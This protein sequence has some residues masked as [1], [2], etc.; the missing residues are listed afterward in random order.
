MGE[1]M[2]TETETSRASC[3]ASQTD[4][5][6]PSESGES[7]RIETPPKRKRG[8]ARVL[9]AGSGRRGLGSIFRSS[10][11]DRKS[12]KRVFAATW[13][14]SYSVGGCQA[15][16]YGFKTRE[17]A[18]AMLEKR[19]N[20]VRD[21]TALPPEL[22]KIVLRDLTDLF[23]LD[24]QQSGRRSAE[25]IRHALK[26]LHAY[27]DD[28]KYPVADLTGNRVKEYVSDRLRSMTRYNRRPAPATINR[29]LAA[30]KRAFHLAA[31]CDPPLVQKI[32]PITM[33]GEAPARSGFFEIA[34]FNR[35][36]AKLPEY[37]HAPLQVARM[38][39]WRVASEV[40]SRKVK[41]LDLAS[42]WLRLDP[43]ETKNGDGREFPLTPALR[44]V[45]VAQRERTRALEKARGEIIPWLFHDD[46]GKP[47]TSFRTAWLNACKR[48]GIRKL[49]Q[50]APCVPR[51]R[52]PST[53]LSTTNQQSVD[54]WGS[55]PG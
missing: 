28:G 37:L 22:R 25:R 30:L 40:L 45:L 48:A 15:R 35:I 43:G 14:I 33:L 32:P 51:P 12:G 6:A 47:I 36:I 41:H 49:P 31:K 5:A 26:P 29:E 53:V 34:D 16:E 2:N 39:G 20:E 7:Q 3:V 1:K 52:R 44:A 54:N 4:L 17:I 8:K 19:L 46:S 38:T 55:R 42:G 13:S 24:C 9:R 11:R 50:R 10:Y 21:G 23:L 27:F 18:A